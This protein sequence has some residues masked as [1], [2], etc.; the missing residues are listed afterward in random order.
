MT[1]RMPGVWRFLPLLALLLPTRAFADPI[2]S[3]AIA[4]DD[5]DTILVSTGLL[6]QSRDGGVHW[7]PVGS[8][9]ERSVSKIVSAGGGRWFAATESGVYRSRDGGASW[10][11]SSAAFSSQIYDLVAAPSSGFTLYASWS[12]G[13]FYTRDGGES[14]WPA[15]GGLP[16]D[17][18]AQLAVD[19]TNAE[20]VYA[21]GRGGLY[22]SP[23]GGANWERKPFPLGPFLTGG[24]LQAAIDPNRPETLYVSRLNCLLCQFAT[25]A[26]STDGGVTSVD[27]LGTYI[28]LVFVIDNASVLFVSTNRELLRS[29]DR[30]TTW[31]SAQAAVPA[32][33]TALA[34]SPSTSL[35]LA[36]SYSGDVYA[37]S[38][39]GTT[40]R[41]LTHPDSGCAA[42]ENGVCLAGRRFNVAVTYLSADGV[43]SPA[44]ADWL[45]DNAGAFWFLTANNVEVVVKVVD[46]TAFNGRTWVFV[47]GL[48]DLEYRVDVRDRST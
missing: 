11:R 6:F 38:D 35:V 24:V 41:R 21:A 15:G 30:G 43:P 37:S 13:V 29:L 26:R 4:R 16:P 20:I 19:P 17:H 31:E 42:G 47:A 8:G 27:V 7:R 2:V 25:L 34:A 12:V 9:I 36:G 1:R 40:W 22:V 48:S 33:V 23:D 44:V 28:Y 14:W 39:H 5:P 10:I 46:G 45:T 32:G 18:R 3:I